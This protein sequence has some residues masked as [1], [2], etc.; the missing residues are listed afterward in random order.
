MT[1]T[2]S[3]L[4]SVLEAFSAP[5]W[6]RFVMTLAH[7]LWQSVII[8]LLLAV[9]LKFI[10][11]RS[12][13]LRYS[14]CGAALL[15]VTASAVMTW[16]WLS[17]HDD[18][19]REL[20]SAPTAQPST[21]TPQVDDSPVA[22]PPSTTAGSENELA[23]SGPLRST[24]DGV[25]VEP[26]RPKSSDSHILTS[27][28][29]SPLAAVAWII[30]VVAM[31][32]RLV[33]QIFAGHRLCRT[34]LPA[35]TET[36]LLVNK[37]AR[38]LGIGKR[39]CVLLTEEIQTPAIMGAL[40]PI[41]LLPGSMLTGLSAEQL[42]VVL[43]HELAHVR[44][45]DYL[46]NLGQMLIESLL[47]FNPAVWWIS[48]QLRI[49]REACADAVAVSQT[50]NR[51]G[52]A[53]ILATL[54]ERLVSAN[55]LG[56]AQAFAGQR[57]SRSLADRIRRLLSPTAVPHLR[58]HWASFCGI[59]TLSCAALFAAE[60]GAQVVVEVAARLLT[61]EERM[62][63]L[64]E[65]RAEVPPIVT[66]SYEPERRELTG[67]IRTEDGEPLPSGCHLT[68]LTTGS[69]GSGSYGHSA[70]AEFSIKVPNM[71]TYLHV[72]ADGYAPTLFGPIP[73][74][75]D[76]SPVAPLDIILK[77]GTP[78]EFRIEDKGGRPIV[79]AEVQCD[80]RV[81]N[82]RRAVGKFNSNSEGFVRL[83]HPIE[84]VRYDLKIRRAGY[85]M[86]TASNLTLNRDRP[87]VI[88]LVRARPTTGVITNVDGRPV[89]HAKVML[90]G[91]VAPDLPGP[92][93]R[94][95]EQLTVT[96]EVGRFTLDTLASG[97][98]YALDI[99]TEKDGRHLIHDVV[100]GE[101][102]RS[103]QLGPE[104]MIEGTLTGDLDRLVLTRNQ[105]RRIPFKER[106]QQAVI[107]GFYYKQNVKSGGYRDSH[108]SQLVL[109]SV[110]D[111]IGHFRIGNLLPGSVML[112]PAG[113]STSVRVEKPVHDFEF[114]IG[115]GPTRDRKL[116][117]EL[118][119]PD[120]EKP[121]G[122]V[123]VHV[124]RPETTDD[125][126][127]EFLPIKDGLVEVDCFAPGRVLYDAHR[128]TG[129][130][131]R[132][133]SVDISSGRSAINH[134]VSTFPAGAVTGVILN[135]DGSP[136]G[137]S[138]TI[139]YGTIEPSPD[140]SGHFG[141]WGSISPTADGKYFLSPIP[142]G[143]TY[144]VYVKQDH[145]LAAVGPLR[146]DAAKPLSKVNIVMPRGVH[147]RGK[148]IDKFNRPLS[149]VPVRCNLSHFTL[150]HSTLSVETDRS[151]GFS[152]GTINPNV[153][154]HFVVVESRKNY[155]PAKII[156]EDLD[157][158]IIIQ[159]K[160]GNRAA[161]VVLDRESGWP[162]PNAEV[163]AHTE[164]L[165]F[166]CEAETRTD[167]KGR[168]RFSNLPAKQMNFKLRG[169]EPYNDP[170]GTIMSEP[171]NMKMTFRVKATQ[172]LR[173]RQ[174][175]GASR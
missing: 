23:Y 69:R 113:R 5:G 28:I 12:S 59:L 65:A 83:E 16:S 172:K 143:G 75:I 71:K 68:A 58:I 84:S 149:G 50:D 144:Y 121:Q 76:G 4:D 152:I 94:Q 63:V 81:E 53:T 27:A 157:K 134:T 70:T 146:L 136:V 26:F 95:P 109:V 31:L 45:H 73:H 100:A 90:F 66:M 8:A 24:I 93:I 163:Y 108:G 155:Q 38:Q 96:D 86:L 82:H 15:A 119:T 11:A 131:F 1:E 54:A 156:V 125:Q 104:I 167:A 48:R 114:H 55:D 111:G 92:H 89:P 88:R 62:E 107:H 116:T 141:I 99:Q 153:R 112:N 130:C 127:H 7:T 6:S 166:Y 165:H 39:I 173:P 151:G 25:P 170:N 126:L 56:T 161:G 110:E 14:L 132:S 74:S 174:P 21:E 154:E 168:F 87:P 52:Y 10:T 150:S 2:H 35:N 47:F 98:I 85:E 122:T 41:L 135:H 17:Y 103:F 158:P 34:Q 3:L 129:Y 120:G 133:G 80:F 42:R 145:M 148:I 175:D 142:L 51:L 115:D 22:D 61:P 128:V 67:I 40:W 13:N 60:K 171:G 102:D 137:S 30:G 97:N 79:G 37:L 20:V 159:L 78:A 19:S 164:G 36:T 43:I 18:Q 162:I 72:T 160:M 138:A 49:E 147:M 123:L 46:V 9:T 105:I 32:V 44:R 77:N 57:K 106:P 169:T 139:D 117:L 101:V 64:T 118:K 140:A 29:L 91:M 124:R 33:A